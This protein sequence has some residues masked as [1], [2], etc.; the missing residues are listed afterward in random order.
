MGRDELAELNKDALI[1]LILRLYDR[2][3]ERETRI[4]RPPRDPVNSSIPPTPTA[5][6]G[7]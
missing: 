4:R 5:G 2:V 6:R 3:M 1:D 7:G